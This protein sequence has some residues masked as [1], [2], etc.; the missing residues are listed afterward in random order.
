MRNGMADS[1]GK[2]A[3]VD[4]GVNTVE[5]YDLYCWYA[6][7]VAGEGLTRHFIKVGLGE[8][9]LIDDFQLYE[10][11]GLFLQKNNVIRNVREDY[12]DGRRFCRK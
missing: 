9:T 7:G 4:A 5:E 11:K 3:F 2:V 1:A 10:S 8:R 6:A 12:D